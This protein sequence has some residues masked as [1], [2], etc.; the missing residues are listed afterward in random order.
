MRIRSS[1]PAFFTQT[2]VLP[3]LER[4]RSA[5]QQF[6]LG[7]YKLF[8]AQY[9]RFM[10]LGKLLKL[11]CQIGCRRLL[12]RC[13]VLHRRWWGILLGLRIGYALLISLIILLLRSSILLRIFLLL[14]V[15]DRAAYRY[16]CPSDDRC[17]YDSA[18]NA[19]YGSSHHCS[20]G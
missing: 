20:S 8:I 5:C 7:H 15:S 16:G 2:K 3:P 10:K 17:A 6:L 13:C 11:G 9:A 18:T 4:K 14:V 12:N 19:S 1:L